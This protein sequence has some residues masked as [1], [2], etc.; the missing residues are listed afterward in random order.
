[1]DVCAALLNVGSSGTTSDS[2]ALQ[3]PGTPLGQAYN[4]TFNPTSSEVTVNAT[5][6]PD[7]AT[8][9][10][11]NPVWELIASAFVRYRVL[12]M[13]FEYMPQAAATTDDQLVFAFANDPFHPIIGILS[14]PAALTNSDLLGLSD[15]VPFMPW[16]EWSLDVTKSF[17]GDQPLFVSRTAG[18]SAFADL[19]FSDGGVFAL[20]NAATSTTKKTYGVL[21]LHS[22]IELEEFCP[23]CHLIQ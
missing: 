17:R 3:L 15:S 11:I 12:K 9:S 14:T 20:T 21:Y 10:W 22:S 23:S 18:L 1:M 2:A 19:R 7:H 16:R 4:A 5:G 6:T 13:V 8:S